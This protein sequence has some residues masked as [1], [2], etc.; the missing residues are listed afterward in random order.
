MSGTVCSIPAGEPFAQTLAAYVLK[1]YGGD[2]PAALGRVRLLLPSR[3][4]CRVMREAFWMAAPD[5]ALILP[6][7]SPLGDVEEEDLALQIFEAGGGM[8][9]IPPSI[10]PQRREILL[11]RLIHQNALYGQG[12]EQALRLAR[13]LARLMDEVSIQGLSYDKLAQLVPEQ[14]AEHWKITLNFL[15]IVTEQWP[16]IL[17][18]RAVIEPAQRRNKL[19]RSLGNLWAAQPPNYPVIAAGSTGSIPATAA[20]LNVISRLPA[21]LVVLPCLDTGMEEQSWRALGP[22]HPQYGLKMLLEALSVVRADVSPLGAQAS[23]NPRTLLAREMMRPAETVDAWK[24]LKAADM[25]PML[26][27]LEAY[28]LPTQHEEA[29]AIALILRECLNT[30]GVTAALITPDRSLARRVRAHCR[31]WGVEVDDSA[32]LPIVDTPLGRWMMISLKLLEPS[33]KP[34]DLMAFLR[35]P[36][37]AL[38]Y[39]Q[40]AVLNSLEIKILRAEERPQS[41]PQLMEMCS[42]DRP[43]ILS[44]MTAVLEALGP[45]HRLFPT[46]QPFVDW[47]DAHLEVLENAAD[48]E[49]LWSGEA[50]EQAAEFFAQLRDNAADFPPMDLSTYA[51]AL[52][53]LLEPVTIRKAYG[54]HPRLSI[55]GQIEARMTR[56]DVVI[57]GSLNEGCWPSESDHDPW[58]SRPMRAAFGLNPAERSIG[59]S[60]HDFVQAFCAPRVILTRAQRVD[61]VPSVPSRWIQRL[62]VVLQAGGRSMTDLEKRPYRRWISLL[63]QTHSTAPCTRPEP[64]PPLSARPNSI[65]ITRVEKWVQ[66]PYSIYA[67]DILGLKPLQ[68]LEL[69]Q[70]ETQRGIMLHR[71][72]EKFLQH[73]PEQLDDAAADTF[74]TIASHLFGGAP[75]I[76]GKSLYWWPRFQILADWF[77]AHEKTWRSM[78]KPAGWEVPARL[79]IP[80]DGLVF[81]LTGKVDRID[82]MAGGYAVVDYK[83]G[84]KYSG[85]K[86]KSG[87][88]PQLPLAAWMLQEGGMDVLSPASA[89]HEESR[90]KRIPRG[91]SV[92]CGYWVLKGGREPAEIKAIL[93]AEVDE[94]I[95]QVREGLIGLIRAFRRA[96][97]PYICIPDLAHRPKYND[98]ENL[99]RLKEWANLD[100]TIEDDAA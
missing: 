15:T 83:T 65:S 89:P 32:G 52:K 14:F 35:H 44:L 95:T 8:L 69:E 97:M 39:G 74:H 29:Q 96:D 21:G 19:L 22:S 58:M 80:L 73:Y 67:R 86:M 77:I 9:D 99:S 53:V 12:M 7:M 92:Y 93:D 33:L 88:L 27:G 70:D 2:D 84:G 26:Q 98:Y 50:G 62:E 72:L 49:T 43:Q 76:Q 68:P 37:C 56:A 38:S 75:G 6:R 23:E 4:A 85:K 87:A 94:A 61:G 63:D 78:A 46:V 36:L 71:V 81:T 47:L 51:E 45:A 1:T 57:L 40:E 59:L 11:A 31:R 10:S 79:E 90:G 82:R 28:V 34:L 13:A 20:L 66:D 18:E 24:A 5:K 30:P 55:L 16:R 25:A 91:S 41:Y 64:C 42:A 100:D 3:R 54:T 60:A 17:A 48:Q